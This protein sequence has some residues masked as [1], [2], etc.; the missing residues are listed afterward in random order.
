M[1]PSKTEHERVL[2]MM[3]LGGSSTSRNRKE[4]NRKFLNYTLL[5]RCSSKI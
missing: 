5:T 3:F 1:K 4:N 2:P